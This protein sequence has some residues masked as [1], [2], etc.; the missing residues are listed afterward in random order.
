MKVGKAGGEKWKSMS[1][2]VS[3]I[4]SSESNLKYCDVLRTVECAL[5]GPGYA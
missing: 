3:S 1:H 2:A 5:S 4:V